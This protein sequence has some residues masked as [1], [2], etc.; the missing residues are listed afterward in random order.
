M[1]IT[2]E[3]CLCGS[4]TFLHTP[5]C[6]FVQM[7]HIYLSMPLNLSFTLRKLTLIELHSGNDCAMKLVLVEFSHVL[8]Q[9]DLKLK[10]YY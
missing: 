2:L 7:L 6:L 3:S 1:V 9:L 5:F 4:N 8:Y 10:T